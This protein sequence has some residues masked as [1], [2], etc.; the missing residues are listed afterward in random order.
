MGILATLRQLVL[1]SLK[2]TPIWD[3]LG[4]GG[5]DRRNRRDRRHRRDRET[6]TLNHKGHEGT[7]KR[8]LATLR[9]AGIAEV[10]ANLGWLG[11]RPCKPLG[12]LVDG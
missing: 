4:E 12:I 5:R 11:M 10:Y 6:K 1:E 8:N 3:G 2:S 9:Q 7:Q